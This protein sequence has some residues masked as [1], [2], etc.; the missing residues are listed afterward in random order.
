MSMEQLSFNDTM[1]ERDMRH[2]KTLPNSM[3]VA[4]AFEVRITRLSSCRTT[5]VPLGS[6]PVETVRDGLRVLDTGAGSG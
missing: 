3:C 1:E 2:Q 4:T 5:V 6:R